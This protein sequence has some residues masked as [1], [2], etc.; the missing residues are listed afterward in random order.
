MAVAEAICAMRDIISFIIGRVWVVLA[1]STVEMGQP[2]CGGCRIR[3][4]FGDK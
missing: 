4:L 3:C 2:L 1:T